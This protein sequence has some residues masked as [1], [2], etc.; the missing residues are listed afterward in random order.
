M[1][2]L[3]WIGIIAVVAVGVF[4]LIRQQNQPL[5]PSRQANSLKPVDRTVFSLEIGDIVQYLGTDWVVEGKLVYNDDGYTWLEYLLQDGDRIRWLSVEEDDQVDV[6][7][8]EPA[9]GLEIAGSPP[10]QL[11]FAGVAYRCIESGTAE[12]T[13]VGATLNRK[14]E[15]CQYFDYAGAD[16]QILSIEDW[17]G[18]LEVM[19]GQRIRPRELCL[20]PGDGRRVYGI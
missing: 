20:L 15:S 2:Q 5:N 10:Q 13:R 12:M 18:E 17:G 14:A 8:L 3:V 16:Q 6:F 4:W 11:N 1:I 9:Q 19:V 7:W